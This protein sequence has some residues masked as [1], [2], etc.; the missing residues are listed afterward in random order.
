VQYHQGVDKL[1][2]LVF[3][4]LVVA[5][6]PARHS[7]WNSPRFRKIP[8]PANSGSAKGHIRSVP[9][10]LTESATG[11]SRRELGKLAPE[12]FCSCTRTNPPF[13]Q[14]LP[15]REARQETLVAGHGP[16]IV[17]SP[18]TPEALNEL[19]YEEEWVP[20]FALHHG[21]RMLV[22]DFR[23]HPR[24]KGSRPTVSPW[25]RRI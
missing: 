3:G 17:S 25:S 6:V 23:L 11:R 1:L 22:L 2:P 19:P 4:P 10:A 14:L 8:F 13:N 12:D 16:F 5:A 24:T 15:N 9:G 18:W 20:G 7:D 21:P